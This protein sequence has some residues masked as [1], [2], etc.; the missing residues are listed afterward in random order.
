MMA[1]EKKRVA[2]RIRLENVRLSFPELWQ[3]KQRM[4]NGQPVGKPKYSAS[5]L[6]P[7][8]ED[9]KCLYHGKR[10]D[11][12]PGLKKAKIAAIA[13]KK[14]ITLE[15]AADF[16]IKPQNYCVQDGDLEKYDGY[17]GCWFVR[18][19]NTE[20]PQLVGLDRRAL[21]ESDGLLKAG[22]RVNAV[23]T[24]WMKLA[25]E[26]DGDPIPNGV[27][28]SLDIIQFRKKDETFG[29]SRPDVEEDLEDLSDD[30]DLVNQD[31]EDDEGQDGGAADSI[32]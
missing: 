4:K 16:I 21:R 30:E 27:H 6:I 5:F 26:R 9:L 17:A 1:E 14:D 15:K 8:D 23:L 12:M 2:G 10:M 20:A 22:Y 7:R 19:S 18:T 31:L 29:I 28:G 25:E 32:L 24:L 13:E 11:I 3:P